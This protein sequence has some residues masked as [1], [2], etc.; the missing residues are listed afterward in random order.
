MVFLLLMCKEG[1]RERGK[2]GKNINI[3]IYYIDFLNS[4]SR[5]VGDQEEVLL[6]GCLYALMSFR[7][8]ENARSRVERG[9]ERDNF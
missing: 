8:E 5:P 7:M 6:G 3:N 2:K 9:N 4:N 1:K